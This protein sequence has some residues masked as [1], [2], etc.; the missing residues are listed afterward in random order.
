M[1][2][3]YRYAA[4]MT[5]SPGNQPVTGASAG[6]SAAFEDDDYRRAVVD[7]LGA[8]AYGEL[9]AFD[10][11]SADARLAPSLEDKIAISQMACVELG[12]L[13]QLRDRIT[14]LGADPSAAMAPFRS[15]LDLFHEHTA[16]ADWWEGLIKAYVGDGMAADFY[17]EIAAY[18]DTRTRDLIV[19]SLEDAG[20]SAFVVDRVKAA[21]AED[22][23]L[24]GRLALWGR[25]LMGEALTQAQRVAAE[26]DALSALLAG[27]VDRPAL[28]LA[29]IGRMFARITER[30]AERMGVLGLDA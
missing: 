2:P 14:E 20:Q 21:I 25:R 13:V 29:A 1:V 12:H 4:S 16:P 15:A 7:L 28:D 8:I 9:T 11:L 30:H 10:R 22:P 24:G 5:E 3:A 27:G 18:L 23:R 6:E 17:R 19:S 26:R